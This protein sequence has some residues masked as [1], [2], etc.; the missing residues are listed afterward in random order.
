MFPQRLLLSPTS[1]T[2]ERETAAARTAPTY[3]CHA[4]HVSVGVRTGESTNTVLNAF[5]STMLKSFS[6]CVLTALAALALTA[7]TPAVEGS[8]APQAQ[9]TKKDPFATG[10][11]RNRPCMDF[12][13]RAATRLSESHA[14][15]GSPR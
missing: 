5:P 8:S 7:Q 1:A 2:E 13:K 4:D 3:V 15:P 11:R 10:R 9:T 12:S 14:L 6:I